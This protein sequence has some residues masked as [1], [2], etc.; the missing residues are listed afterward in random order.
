[1]LNRA[2][3]PRWHFP[4]V[5]DRRRNAAFDAAIRRSVGADSRVLDIG[6]GTGLLALM[7][8]RAGARSVVA[9]ESNANVAA[10]AR[11]VIARNG[12]AE[13]ITVH[14]Q[15]SF[16]LR[17]GHELPVRADVVLA[18]V[19]DSAVIG[20]GVLPTLED[21]LARLCTDDCRVIPCRAEL[22]AALVESPP[23]WAQGAV[24]EIDGFD[25]SPLNEARPGLL[26]LDADR[27]AMR[28]LSADVTLLDF[29]FEPGAAPTP[30]TSRVELA[31][32]R[33]GLAHAVVY[34]MRLWLDETEAIDNRPDFGD[35][36]SAGVIEHWG[37]MA[38]LLVRPLEV[39]PGQRLRI[40]TQHNRRQITVLPHD[41]ATGAL[42]A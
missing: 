38:R 16:A 21:A 10:I 5:H 11:E 36:E 42:L 6:T 24:D 25:L 27:L 22:R 29:A 23:L 37:P 39:K 18:E 35:G 2:R 14:A 26:G 9:C 13:R 4:M 40:D 32:T 20:E 33:P 34:W 1:L 31:A 12:F 8:A 41:L 15:P 17:V 3:V 28:A 30:L 7:A 19:F